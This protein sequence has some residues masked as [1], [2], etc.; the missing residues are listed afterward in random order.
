[1]TEA[2]EDTAEVLDFGAV[3]CEHKPRSNHYQERTSVAT[4][5]KTAVEKSGKNAL[6]GGS[7]NPPSGSILK[8]GGGAS[9]KDK[10]GKNKK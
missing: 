4:K 8:G 9:S 6:K 3:L 10:G 5:K 7:G 2:D 1:V